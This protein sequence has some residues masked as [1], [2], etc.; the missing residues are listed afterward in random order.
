MTGVLLTGFALAGVYGITESF[1]SIDSIESLPPELQSANLIETFHQE[2]PAPSP[3]QGSVKI[4]IFIYHSVR[5][6]IA[7]E[8]MMQE[9]Y[10]ISP[11]LLEQ[12]L[13]YLKD[14]G[15]TAITLDQLVT[16]IE[17]GTTS[18]SKPV[19][20]TFDD[21]WENQYKNAFPLLKKYHMTATF[22]IY[23]NPI[24]TLHYL[25]WDEIKEMDAAGMT[26]GDHTL[27]HPYLKKLSIDQ[28]TKE[29]TQSKTIIEKHLGKPVVHFASPFGYSNPNIMAVVKAAGYN[30]A[31]TTYKGTY[32]TKEE[33]F[34][35]RGVLVTDSFDYFV[36]ELKN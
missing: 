2:L 33:L 1:E 36:A 15:Y 30:T 14:N 17:M 5:P 16:D 10:D 6:H 18:N 13:K 23:T 3:V 26:I 29:V 19:V 28:L 11:E 21:G 35:L 20:L 22:F 34:K 4:P 31:R 12:Q 25:T 7:G 8:S 27:S 24:G 32:H 9:A